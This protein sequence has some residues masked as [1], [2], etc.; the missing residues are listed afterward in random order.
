MAHT[1]GPMDEEFITTNGAWRSNEGT[2][3]E[4]PERRFYPRDGIDEQI[5]AEYRYHVRTI[6]VA[7][8]RS[9]N[10]SPYVALLGVRALRNNVDRLERVAVGIARRAAW[11]WNDIGGVLGLS[12][13]AAQK[14]FARPSVPA[15]RRRVAPPGPSGTT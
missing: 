1:P 6:A 14:R 5:V 12:R 9:V 8:Q 3:F 7:L 2:F 15:R 10:A 11:S 4:L 13:S